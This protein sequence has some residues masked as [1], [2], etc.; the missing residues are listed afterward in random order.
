MNIFFIDI[1]SNDLC[2]S[3]DQVSLVQ[4]M[5]DFAQKLVSLGFQIVIFSEIL[6][7]RC[8]GHFSSKLNETNDKLRAE[9]TKY[10]NFICWSHYRNNYTIRFLTDY[11]P[12]DGITVD[13]LR[14]MPRY[15]RSLRGAILLAENAFGDF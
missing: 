15:F 11:V 10:P 5:I 2:I 8:Q 13:Y 6:H 3:V 7:R 9:C 12:V 14:G 1:G 4:C